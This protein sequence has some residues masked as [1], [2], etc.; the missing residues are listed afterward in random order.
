MLQKHTPC[1]SRHS[2][3]GMAVIAS[4]WSHLLA[5]IPQILSGVTGPLN[6]PGL[7]EGFSNVGRQ[8]IDSVFFPAFSCVQTIMT[9][10]VKH[11]F[12]SPSLK[13]M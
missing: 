12:V 9:K 3:T 5:G 13:A 4:R 11:V 6:A 1:L 2:D 10:M 8:F 7:L